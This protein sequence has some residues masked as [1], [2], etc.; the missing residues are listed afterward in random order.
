[1]LK[2]IFFENEIINKPTQTI[3]IP[4][5]PVRLTSDFKNKIL[6]MAMNKHELPLEI[7]YM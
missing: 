3:N 6:I 1:M 5:K 7:G 2:E 4:I